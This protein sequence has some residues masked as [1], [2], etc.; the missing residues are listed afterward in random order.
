M[1][2]HLFAAVLCAASL[3]F[4]CHAQPNML[5]VNLVKNGDAEAGIGSPQCSTVNAP[6]WTSVGPF[7]VGIYGGRSDVLLDTSPGP[8]LFGPESRG[9]NFFCGGNGA[10]SKASQTID[11]SSMANT[12]DSGNVKFV[13]SGWLGGDGSSD[14]NASV[15]AT[16]NGQNITNG[17]MN[18]LQLGPVNA[19]DRSNTTSLAFKQLSGVIPAG[20]R[21]ITIGLNMQRVNGVL[22]D[23]YADNI[24]FIME[25]SNNQISSFNNFSS[26]ISGTTGTTS[27]GSTNKL[28]AVAAGLGQLLGTLSTAMGNSGNSNFNSG[29][30]NFNSGNSN[31][32][33]GSPNFNGGSPNLNSGSPNFNGGNSNL[34]SGSPNFNG[35]NSNLNSGSPNFNSGS[36]N[37]NSG[38]P[39]FNSG[40]PNFNSGS[41][42]F[43]SGSP[44]FNSGSPNLNSGS[45]NF[46]SGSPNLNSGSP[47]F[48][49]G[50]PNL[51]SGSPNFNSGNSNFNS[52]SP[53]LNSGSSNFNSGSP[54]FNSGNSNFNSG[55]PNFN[56][57]NSNFNSGSPNFSGLVNNTALSGIVHEKGKTTITLDSDKLFQVKSTLA[58]GA[59]QV[60]EQIRLSEFSG[61]LPRAIFFEGHTDEMTDNIDCLALSM[62]RALAI[63]DWMNK[64]GVPSIHFEARGCGRRSPKS[65]V[66]NGL[67]QSQNRR[68][69]IVL[70]D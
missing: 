23:A 21:S 10:A 48:N 46:N 57:G 47:N 5:G 12:I 31:F 17:S 14:D 38:S 25:P 43:N 37:L 2:R 62:N 41:P 69:E 18:R 36:P 13:F 51:N 50:S 56:S 35:G 52:G 6:N 4:P 66:V 65:T 16:F 20:T 32:N 33:S 45:P 60:L 49:S 70:V 68:I 24:S 15:S 19:I 42:N 29:N 11:I 61:H 3:S 63:T 39:N 58:P 67:I 8:P 1:K 53:N 40:S 54:N 28:G 59:E 27:S 7:T 9:K 55:S 26:N 44:N 22:N 30:S 64:H 34:N